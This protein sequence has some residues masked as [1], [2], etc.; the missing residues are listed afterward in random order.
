MLFNRRNF[1]DTPLITAGAAYNNTGQ[2][3]AVARKIGFT[4]PGPL[5]VGTAPISVLAAS[6]GVG[7]LEQL[8]VRELGTQKSQLDVFFFDTQPTLTGVDQGAFA[9]AAGEWA[10]C[11]GVVNVPAA[12][13]R[14]SGA[15]S[16]AVV[17]ISPGLMLQGAVKS[18]E[19]WYLAV[20]RG[21]PTYGTTA[22][23]TFLFGFN[24]P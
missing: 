24:L 15:Q 18:K 21:T 20:S 13:Y 5:G 4:N 10:K 1:S 6:M 14:S 3:G 23:L 8:V 11:I 16:L 19:L 17:E 12:N 2:I 22:D 9:M 7:M